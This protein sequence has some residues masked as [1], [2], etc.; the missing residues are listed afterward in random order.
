MA[1]R[2]ATRG[3]PTTYAAE[4]SS[5]RSADRVVS[6]KVALPRHRSSQGNARRRERPR[7][8]RNR[9][10][11]GV[12]LA[13]GQPRRR[14][15]AYVVSGFA[16]AA[17]A[18]SIST[19]EREPSRASGKSPKSEPETASRGNGSR[20]QAAKMFENPGRGR[21]RATDKATTSIAL[22]DRSIPSSALSLTCLANLPKA[23]EVSGLDPLARGPS[24]VHS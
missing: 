3:S 6:R 16:G 2:L 10:R 1:T 7:I 12:S 18:P 15:A 14:R 24:L 19:A 9:R 17:S 11:N 5:A 8:P 21:R 13:A 20:A 23:P 22:R 4:E